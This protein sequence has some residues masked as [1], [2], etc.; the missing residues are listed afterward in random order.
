MY[1]SYSFGK[2]ATHDLLSSGDIEVHL[3][4]E[5][6]GEVRWYCKHHEESLVHYATLVT[7]LLLPLIYRGL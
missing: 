2:D 7:I 5:G 1:L 6:E 3:R 4:G